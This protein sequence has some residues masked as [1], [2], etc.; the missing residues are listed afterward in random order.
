MSIGSCS[1]S[2]PPARICSNVASQQ[3]TLREQ[4]RGRLAVRLRGVRIGERRL[5]DD[6]HV[7]LRRRADGHPAH[8]LVLDVVTDLQAEHVA[9]EG[10]RLVVVVD[11]DEALCEFDSHA[12]HATAGRPPW[13]LHS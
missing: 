11:G 5:E 2:A 4:L 10:E 12:P 6:L 1:T 3:L 7:G 13:L 8:P 9:V